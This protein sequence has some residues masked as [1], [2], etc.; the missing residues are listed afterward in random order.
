[1]EVGARL[2]A[3]RKQRKITLQTLAA[4]SGLSAAYLSNLERDAT[5]PT[6][7]NLQR[8]CDILEISVHSLL[9]DISTTSV[10][11]RDERQEAF[12][13]S[14]GIRCELMTRG[15]RKMKVFCMTVAAD[16]DEE[17]SSPGY[18]SDAFCVVVQ[19]RLEIALEGETYELAKGDSIYITR[20]VPHRY[21][22]LSGEECV[23][24]WV[25]RDAEEYHP[26]DV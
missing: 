8:I 26:I 24:Y 10:V 18:S 19:G 3:L 21:H 6:L 13:I 20:G 2:K 9:H 17:E 15:N 4:A 16:Y 7:A 12:R 5:S 22:K 23:S 1:M 14:P 25:L 11:R